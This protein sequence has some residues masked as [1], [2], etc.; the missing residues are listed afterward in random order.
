MTSINHEF[1]TQLETDAR[2][3]FTDNLKS[4]LLHFIIF[5]FTI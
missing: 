2:G 5:Q 4:L 3:H 1:N